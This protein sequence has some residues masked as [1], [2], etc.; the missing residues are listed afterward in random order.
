MKYFQDTLKTINDSVNALDEPSFN[1][2]LEDCLTTLK[3]GKKIIASGLGKNVPICE[4]FVGT[5]NSLGIP[6]EFL[7]TNSAMHGDIGIVKDGDLVI[8]LSKS[9][10]TKE[11]IQL[12]DYLKMLG[13]NIW[14]L[15]FCSDSYLAMHFEKKLVLELDSEGDQWNIVPNNSTTIYLIILQ[16]LALLIAKRQKVVLSD[17]KRN[18]PGGKIGETLN[19][20]DF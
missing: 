20:K 7:H 18:H 12:A 17:F 15:T 6:A 5:L 9:G 4:K 8:I 1:R 10:G 19:G 13:I 11:S 14:I 16:G 2:L 3:N